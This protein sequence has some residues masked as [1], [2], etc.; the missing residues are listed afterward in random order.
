MTAFLPD[1]PGLRDRAS[2]W[3][4]VPLR[5]F[6]GATFIYAGLDK[7]TDP[8][9]ISTAGNGSIGQQMA[10]V[11]DSAAFPA[12]VDFALRDPAM[13]GAA[14]ALGELVVGLGVLIGL[15]GRLAAAGGVLISL[16]LWLTVS[17]SATPYYYGNDLPY[18]VAWTALLLAGTPK[19]SMDYWISA[20]RQHSGSRGSR[21]QTTHTDGW[22]RSR[23]DRETR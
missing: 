10:A 22:V 23:G 19:L 16:S 5:L 1:A 13:F 6:L 2:G 20:S 9:F 4:L 21:A 18:L 7:L 11:R 17:W 8:A 15:L 14:M 12:L 3:A